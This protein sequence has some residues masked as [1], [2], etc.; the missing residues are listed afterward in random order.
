[1][2]TTAERLKALTQENQS[3]GFVGDAYATIKTI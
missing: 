2:S 1:M 3:Q